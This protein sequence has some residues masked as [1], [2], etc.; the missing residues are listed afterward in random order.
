MA[1]L[2]TEPHYVLDGMGRRKRMCPTCGKIHWPG[3]TFQNDWVD[4]YYCRRDR[5]GV[6]KCAGC[7]KELPLSEF[8]QRK[9]KAWRCKACYN[10]YKSEWSAKNSEKVQAY[11]RKGYSGLD[12]EE[13]AEDLKATHCPICRREFGDTA[14]TK[15][16]VDH[17]HDTGAY[18]GVIC[19]R[20]NRALGI[21]GD[22]VE[23]L[24]RALAY[25]KGEL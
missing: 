19:G 13:Y 8:P 11:S 5:D 14:A 3:K 16:N 4:C 7:K 25:L 17:C 22:S 6:K 20:C 10:A 12:Y 1:I 21:L 2:E 18:R 24:G 15:Q 9:H 23:S